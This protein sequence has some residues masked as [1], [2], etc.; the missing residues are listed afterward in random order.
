MKDLHASKE[1]LQ[2]EVYSMKNVIRQLQHSLISKT[3]DMK[4]ECNEQSLLKKKTNSTHKAA[5][6]AQ[7]VVLSDLY[8]GK[9][10]RIKA[11]ISLHDEKIA[12]KD[13]TL[14]EL[15]LKIQRDRKM[16]NLVSCF[17]VFSYFI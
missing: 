3:E 17:F 15:A 12:K 16:S 5:M 6:K 2:C 9:D 13:A 11:L 7:Q 8:Q 1:K 4:R 14:K 10:T